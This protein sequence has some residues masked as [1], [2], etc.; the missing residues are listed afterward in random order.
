[1]TRLIK[2]DENGTPYNICGQ[3]QTG[4][5]IPIGTSSDTSTIAGAVGDLTTLTTTD[6]SSVVGAVNELHDKTEKLS[7]YYSTGSYIQAS[8]E[9]SVSFGVTFSG[10]PMVT[11]TP[12]NSSSP[13]GYIRACVITEVTTTGFKFYEVAM[14]NG[15][16]TVI[17]GSDRCYWVAVGFKA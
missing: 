1:M 7:N 3:P 16:N 8:G 14:Q 13:T 17:V 12:F 5:D 2:T 11:V 10:A 9:T 6:K 4:A 15:S